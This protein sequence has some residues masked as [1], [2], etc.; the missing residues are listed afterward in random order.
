MI[1]RRTLGR[2]TTFNDS[3]TT[4]NSFTTL[5]LC[6][7]KVCIYNYDNK[8]GGRFFVSIFQLLY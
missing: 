5:V 6:I 8:L 7:S 4:L 1:A 3:F 2:G